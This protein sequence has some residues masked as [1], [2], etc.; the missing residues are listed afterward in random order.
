MP[1]LRLV[2][3]LYSLIADAI[4][5]DK[6]PNKSEMPKLFLEPNVER[7][8]Y[9]SVMAKPNAFDYVHQIKFDKIDNYCWQY[10]ENIIE[11]STR[12]M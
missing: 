10:I 9:K 1:L 7:F 6:E 12:Y 8:S 11:P 4:E 5:F 3:Q 2:H